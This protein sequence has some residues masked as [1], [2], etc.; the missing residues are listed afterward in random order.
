MKVTFSAI[1]ICRWDSVQAPVK[2][3]FSYWAINDSP[4]ALEREEQ[5]EICL[6]KKGSYLTR[7]AKNGVIA[8]TGAWQGWRL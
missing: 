1:Y 2:E 3:R 8:V 4:G 5:K 7:K 6:Q